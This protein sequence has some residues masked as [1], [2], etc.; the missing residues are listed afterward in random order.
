MEERGGKY[1]ITKT[2]DF[3]AAH[4]LPWHKGACK[5]LHGHRYVV[6]VTVNRKDNSLDEN[7]I[8]YDLG[9]LGNTLKE[10]ADRLDHSYLNDTFENPTAENIA[11]WFRINTEIRL[12]IGVIVKRAVVEESP[13]SSVTL[14]C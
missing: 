5:N 12:P 3:C 10:L 7:D 2:V 13:G 1:S 14:E 4:K 6:S 9:W 8:V 11:E